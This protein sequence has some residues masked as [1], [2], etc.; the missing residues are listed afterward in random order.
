[1]T[2]RTHRWETH[3][4]VV[5]GTGFGGAVAACRLAQ[6]GQRPLVLERGRRYGRGHRPFPRRRPGVDTWL[7]AHG[8]GPFD[9]AVGDVLTLRAAGFGGGSLLYS[10]VHLRMPRDGF[11]HGWPS[12]WTREAL[13][14]YYALVEHMLEV[15]P[16]DEQQRRRVPPR[17]TV[18]E[19]AAAAVGRA[20]QSFRPPLA[21]TFGP[22]A[23]PVD[24]PLR[25]RHGVEQ[26][27]CTHCAECNVGCNRGAKNSLD[28][29]YL[30]VAE[31]HGAVVR[32][33][34]EVTGLTREAGGYRVDY[35]DHADGTIVHVHAGTVVLAAGAIGTTALLLDAREGLGLGDQVGR[36]YSANGDLVSAGLDL[37][38]AFVPTAG[39][40]ITTALL[41][42]EGPAD[43]GS[44][45]PWFLVQDGGFPARFVGA[46][47]AAVHGLEEADDLVERSRRWIDRLV[48]VTGG[49]ARQLRLALRRVVD[50][51]ADTPDHDTPDHDGTR[52]GWAEVL[53]G[54]PYL[55]ARADADRVAVL[56]AMGRDSADGVVRVPWWRR[57]LRWHRRRPWIDWDLAAN[58]GLYAAEQALC[59]ELVERG[60]GGEPRGV[61]A[62]APGLSLSVH[63]LGGAVMADGPGDGVVDPHG[64]VFGCRGLFV[65]D[66]AAIPTATG[67]N[68]SS[69]IAAVAERNVERLVRRLRDEP[70]WE[71]PEKADAGPGH[72]P[73][74]TPPPGG[75]RRPRRAPVFV[76]SAVGEGEL[77]EPG[78]TV[79]HLRFRLDLAGA[80]PER[81]GA[82]V[83][84]QGDLTLDGV[85]VRDAVR[86]GRGVVLTAHEDRL[87][88]LPFTAA[89]SPY[90]LRGHEAGG[91]LALTLQRGLRPD[92]Q[93][94]AEGSVDLTVTRA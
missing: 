19:N 92:A 43:D 7:W 24:A 91:R 82:T 25:N 1:M 67:V 84:A 75:H 37:D 14:G 51:V 69:T 4:V 38:V 53:A 23:G 6:G 81:V 44:P 62:W 30:A 54:V 47:L 71:A 35:T 39:P 3:P 29:N 77:R 33:E 18:L 13:D 60:M 21:V 15:T 74:P 56:L 22:P 41:H 61:P 65:L 73:V 89:G 70:G 86:V 26:R 83:S 85:G 34:C 8:R 55:A 50:L 16:I 27:G 66:G 72:D 12:G 63:S 45:G 93:V 87:W 68:P 36:R 20:E 17:T 58:T 32:T 46:I 59:D 52:A 28:M 40:A 80:D 49:G 94:V 57:V 88:T 48:A 10:N 9:V 64:E 11:G 76:G 31:R 90:V 42:S 2:E 79:R 78:G 5:V